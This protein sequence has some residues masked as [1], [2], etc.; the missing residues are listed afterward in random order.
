MIAA[1]ALASADFTPV[2]TEKKIKFSAQ[3][4][5]LAEVFPRLQGIT[6]AVFSAHNVSFFCVSKIQL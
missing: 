1:A 2:V 5:R 6:M 4:H 3:W